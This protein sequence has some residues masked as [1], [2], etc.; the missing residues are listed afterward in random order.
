[1]SK[2]WY[3]PYKCQYCFKPLYNKDYLYKVH[4]YAQDTKKDRTLLFNCTDCRVHYKYSVL[5]KKT[6]EISF[7]ITNDRTYQAIIIPGDEPNFQIKHYIR[8]TDSF[9]YGEETLLDFPY[10]PK[11]FTPQTAQEKLKL[12]LLFS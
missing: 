6:T 2:K 3:P 11:N 10:I 5:H 9:Q 7:F 8:Y 4:M 1:M 12:Y